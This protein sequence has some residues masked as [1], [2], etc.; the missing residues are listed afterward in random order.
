M[1]QFIPY[2]PYY[3][4][5]YYYQ[6]LTYLQNA[7]V[8]A[9][10]SNNPAG[11][12]AIFALIFLI[13]IVLCISYVYWYLCLSPILS[14]WNWDIIDWGFNFD[15]DSDS[16]SSSSDSDCCNGNNG[17]ENWIEWLNGDTDI[18][19]GDYDNGW[20]DFFPDDV[21]IMNRG[22]NKG[23]NI[24]MKSS[25]KKNKR[26]LLRKGTNQFSNNL[27]KS[28]IMR[29]NNINRNMTQPQINFKKSSSQNQMMPNRVTLNP[30]NNNNNN[31]FTLLGNNKEKNLNNNVNND[32]DL[33]NLNEF[34]LN[35][36]NNFNN[37][38]KPQNNLA[39]N[40]R[41]IYADRIKEQMENNLKNNSQ[42]VNNK[43][44]NEDDIVIIDSVNSRNEKISDTNIKA[45]NSIL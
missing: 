2:D 28:Q 45:K 11:L 22:K 36:S 13:V 33:I 7:Q 42:Y 35:N 1:S 17:N 6:Y 27:L 19:W 31:K 43:V 32:N 34:N 29:G 20:D 9:E 24:K 40:L 37:Y 44:V 41:L 25:K 8:A 15:S 26:K 39:A 16:S 38:N 12:L 23:N 4:Q 5:L 3:N 14:S 10:D 21:V 18:N 30:T